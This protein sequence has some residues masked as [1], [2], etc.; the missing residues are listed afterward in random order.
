LQR[1]SHISDWP[2]EIKVLDGKKNT[3]NGTLPRR[4]AS[5][6]FFFTVDDRVFI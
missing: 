1:K 3:D 5:R 2:I 4:P 6:S